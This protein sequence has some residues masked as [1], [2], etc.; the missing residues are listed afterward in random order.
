MAARG[1]LLRKGSSKTRGGR[2]NK[3]IQV[4]DLVL[5]KDMG[6]FPDAWGN[7]DLWGTVKK[8]YPSGHMR[9]QFNTLFEGFTTFFECIAA[10]R[11]KFSQRSEDEK[12]ARAHE[13]KQE[14]GLSEG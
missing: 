14:S 2:L 4:G 12:R 8:I 9:I 11:I 1:N 5:V 7:T 3:M 10:Q 6:Y 13:K